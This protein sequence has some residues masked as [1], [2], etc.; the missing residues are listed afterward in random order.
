M[1]FGEK[2]SPNDNIKMELYKRCEDVNCFC[3]V[4]DRNK[5]GAVV[6]R[7]MNCGVS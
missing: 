3:L 7:V 5:G 4:R 2:M 1:L 6:N